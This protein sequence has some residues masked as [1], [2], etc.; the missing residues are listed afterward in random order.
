MYAHYFW[1]CKIFSPEREK[2]ETTLVIKTG[3]TTIISGYLGTKVADY[4][5]IISKVSRTMEI[6]SALHFLSRVS[7]MMADNVSPPTPPPLHP[8]RAQLSLSQ[9]R[10]V[11]KDE[12]SLT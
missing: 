10:R 7:P 4:V 12:P 2:I 3:E 6:R 5:S 9:K 1:H 11:Q 8:I